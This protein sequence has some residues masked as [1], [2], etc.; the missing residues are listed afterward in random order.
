MSPTVTGGWSSTLLSVLIIM[1][2]FHTTAA[3]YTRG[4]VP[5]PN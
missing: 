5:P 3:L 1:V 2:M 4:R